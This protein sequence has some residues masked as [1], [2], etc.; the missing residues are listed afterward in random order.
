ML[1][2]F[3]FMAFNNNLLWNENEGKELQNVGK[4]NHQ[5]I[6]EA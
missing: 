1:A 4:L 3:E 6:K 2:V 5:R